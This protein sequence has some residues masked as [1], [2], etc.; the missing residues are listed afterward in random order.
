[1]DTKYQ[2]LLGEAA[3]A[4]KAAREIAEKA[5]KDNGREMTETER[6]E[7]DAKFA[8]ATEKKAAA[9]VAK[10]DA[11]VMAQA[12]ELAELVGLPE[13]AKDDL[14]A[15]LRNATREQVR[16]SLGAEIVGSAAF[17]AAMA[18]FGDRVPEKARFQTDPISVKS[19][20]RSKSLFVGGSDTSAGAFV[21]AE[22]SGIVE[23]LGRREYR[24]RDLVS[25][26][27]TGSDTVEY[28]R[29]TSH[30]NSAAPVAEA[31]SSAA[32]TTGA[33]SGAA[34]TLNPNG[35]YKPEGAWAFERDTATV[36][37]IA[38]WVPATKRSL[39][40]VGQLE[41]LINDELRKD[42]EETED[43]QILNGSGSGENLTGILNTSGIQTQAF[44]TD[45]FQSVR[46]GITLA[47]TVGRVNP[48]GIV[49]N[50]TD[51]EIVDLAQDAN[52][53]YYGLG[54]FSMGPRTLWGLPIVES[55]AMG[56]G[57][58]LLGDFSKAVLWDR[59]QTTVTMTDSHADFF[60]RNLVAVLAEERVAFAVT[61]PTAFVNVDIAA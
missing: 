55:E 32:P 4:A 51:V 11:E 15:Q 25:V 8:E 53:R 50:P 34:L 52:N 18:P 12:K 19:F 6:A 54:P 9:D 41:G 14:D 58:A 33:S 28:V 21:V 45:L 43:T 16:K 42:I 40:D 35:G 1:M 30:T 47:K 5:D 36:K 20:I 46:K 61:R 27:T 22:Q 38:E 2:R 23:M 29:Q 26:R 24:L 56:A 7:F 13:D 48:S 57:H 10:K 3:A 37:T 59:E 39:A 49:M 60:I 44:A 17:K 31:T